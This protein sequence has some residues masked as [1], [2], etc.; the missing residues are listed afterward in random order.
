VKPPVLLLDVDGVLNAFISKPNKAI[1]PFDTWRF[2]KARAADREW[3][4]AW[5]TETVNWL[6][7]LDDSGRAE[8]RW[9]TTWLHD[10]QNIADLL[11]L[12]RF[13]VADSTPEVGDDVYGEQAQELK[14]AR[15]RDGEPTWWKYG[16]AHRVLTEEGRALLW[17]DDDLESK[18]PRRLRDLMQANHAVLF[19][20]PDGH[21]GLIPRHL[22]QAEQFLD[23]VETAES[24]KALM[25]AVKLPPLPPELLGS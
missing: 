17:F 14:S 22:R 20:S 24:A 5:S 25:A 6:N 23:A 2:G 9:H 8:I 3:P 15:L 12:N 4:I 19:I 7:A 1:W 21:T 13:A 11:G 16:A 10:A 18:L